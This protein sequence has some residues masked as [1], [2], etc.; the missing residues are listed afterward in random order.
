MQ[1]LKV[2]LASTLWQPSNLLKALIGV[3][4]IMILI[5]FFSLPWELVSSWQI[6]GLPLED[7]VSSSLDLMN[8]I[9][10][11]HL[12]STSPLLSLLHSGFTLPAASPWMYCMCHPEDVM[13]G[14]SSVVSFFKSRLH[15]D[16][17]Q[18]HEMFLAVLF[19]VEIL[20]ENLADSL[21]TSQDM[22][23]GREAISWLMNRLMLI[24]AKHSRSL[25]TWKD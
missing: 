15:S 17:F 23:R 14:H 9:L 11:L 7:Q 25:D 19:L 16:A 1:V 20:V 12:L 5:A 10:L 8:S 2:S 24:L 4:T 18:S 22:Q 3:N 6:A 21:A 13:G